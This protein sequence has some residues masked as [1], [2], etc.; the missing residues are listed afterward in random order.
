[1]DTLA[2]VIDAIYYTWP[3]YADM[4]S[5]LL[6]PLTSILPPGSAVD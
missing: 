6:L 4:S 5:R 2:L 3:P 1:M